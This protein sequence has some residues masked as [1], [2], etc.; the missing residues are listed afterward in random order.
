MEFLV[1]NLLK[2]EQDLYD[3]ETN[4]TGYINLGTAVNAL[5]EDL[6]QER[7]TKVESWRISS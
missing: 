2:C 7:L 3:S 4:K 5:V 1:R 6:I